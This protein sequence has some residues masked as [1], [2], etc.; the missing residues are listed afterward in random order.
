MQ[1]PDVPR[2]PLMEVG[3]DEDGTLKFA[4]LLEMPFWETSIFEVPSI[5]IELARKESPYSEEPVPVAVCVRVAAFLRM[6]EVKTKLDSQ[7]PLGPKV[8][9]VRVPLSTTTGRL[10]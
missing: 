3:P 6:M 2:R 4:V 9:M 7:E 10:L 1:L 5:L 8:F